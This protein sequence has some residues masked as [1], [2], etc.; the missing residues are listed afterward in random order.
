MKWPVEEGPLFIGENMDGTTAGD[1]QAIG[2]GNPGEELQG[3][4]FIA[5]NSRSNDQHLV[6]SG[7][8]FVLQL[9]AYHRRPIAGITD[10]LGVKLES[11]GQSVTSHLHPGHIMPVPSHLIGIHLVEANRK[12]S[13]KPSHGASIPL[14][15]AVNPAIVFF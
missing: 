7:R 15:L 12:R 2:A 10:L 3:S 6:E 14:Q 4:G 1:D 11:S 9:K 8:P 13:F 5:A